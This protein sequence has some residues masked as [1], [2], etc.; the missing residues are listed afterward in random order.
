MLLA[1]PEINPNPGEDIVKKFKELWGSSEE[2]DDK[3]LA[4]HVYLARE[5]TRLDTAARSRST[6]VF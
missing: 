5:L 1:H 6:N 4:K 2:W 3:Q